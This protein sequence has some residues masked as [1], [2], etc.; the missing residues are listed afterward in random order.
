MDDHPTALGLGI[1]DHQSPLLAASPSLIHGV[2]RMTDHTIQA[3]TSIREKAGRTELSLVHFGR[4]VSDPGDRGWERWISGVERGFGVL[5]TRG[6][7]GN[8]GIDRFVDIGD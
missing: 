4:W 2:G 6:N 1:T 5:G 3:S 7:D 8:K